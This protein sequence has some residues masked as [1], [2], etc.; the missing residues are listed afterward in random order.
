MKLFF[1]Q[2]CL[3][4]V[5]VFSSPL[6]GQDYFLS[7]TEL[8]EKAEKFL[9]QT[10]KERIKYSVQEASKFTSRHLKNN[11]VNTIWIPVQIHIAD[12]GARQAIDF[13]ALSYLLADVNEG[14][15]S[16]NL[17]LYSCGPTNI[18]NDPNIYTLYTSNNS[19]LDNH[20]VPGKLNLYFVDD[21]RASAYGASYCGSSS[22]PGQGERIVMS[23]GCFGYSKESTM[24]HLIGQYLSLF[25][26]HGPNGATPE[27]VDGTNCSTAGDEICDTPADPRL[28][29]SG[30]MSGCSYVAPNTVVDPKGATYNPDTTNYMSYATWDCRDHFTPQ[31]KARMYYSATNDRNYLNCASVPACSQTITQYPYYTSFENGLENWNTEP[32]YGYI[33]AGDFMLQAGP[34]T[35]SG[36]GPANASDGN[37]YIYA[38]ADLIPTTSFVYPVAVIES[39]CFDLRSLNVPELSFKYHMSGTGVGGLFVQIS[40]DGGFD[41][42]S[43]SGNL[44][45]VSGD[46]GSN[47][48]SHSVD[49]SNYTSDSLVVIRFGV[50]FTGSPLGD[51]A[52]DEVAIQE[53]ANCSAV[54]D[55][56]VTPT[57][58]TCFGDQD[59]SA[60]LSLSLPGTQP[61][62]VTWSNGATNVYQIDNLA[63]GNY[64]VTVE[65]ANN[66]VDIE[67]FDILAPAQPLDFTLTSLSN[68]TNTAAAGDLKVVTNSGTPPYDYVWS[69]GTTGTPF[70]Q[71]RPTGNYS[72]TV[73]DATGCTK[74]AGVYLGAL[75]ACNG[76][77][78]NWPYTLDLE[79]NTGLFK[80]NSDDDFN[81]RKRIGSTPTSGTGPSSAAEGNYYRYMEASGW[82]NPDKSAVLTTKKCLDLSGLSNPVFE[83]KYHMFGNLDMGSLGVQLSVDGGNTWLASIW[84][85]EGDQGNIWHQASIPLNTYVNNN[86]RIR[87]VGITGNGNRSDIAIDDIYIGEA[88]PNTNNAMLRMTKAPQETTGE[89]LMIQNM[90]PNPASDKI[91]L[92]LN[93][94]KDQESYQI[95]IIHLTGKVVEQVTLGG[96]GQERFSLDISTLSNGLYYLVL[97]DNKGRIETLPLAINRH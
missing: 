31:Q 77:K 10:R 24:L 18:I 44:F 25:P 68:S 37:Q 70:L 26:T 60:S 86:L 95:Q 53:S 42:F 19:L 51:V 75:L 52:I 28:N 46:Q 81:W 63:P 89:G 69:D 55:A 43:A 1:T 30:Y 94:P 9:A 2:V 17:Q 23:T 49:L 45:S 56:V 57:N 67:S 34:T 65:D 92:E 3:L 59:G 41:W 61:I 48:L 93:L 22:Y 33:M 21:L 72:V 14:L 82:R 58:I 4:M 27:F 15:R 38:E 39:P 80:Q 36:T 85:Q 88:I 50:Q 73:T 35:T 32:F 79:G 64:S 54:L 97:S 47:W 20:D 76:T 16:A 78:T 7:A 87:V 96:F 11:N 90:Y 40:T 83:F 91:N 29:Q 71:A 74:S 66:C 6:N 62:T 13:L 84:K 5:F 8:D 12:N